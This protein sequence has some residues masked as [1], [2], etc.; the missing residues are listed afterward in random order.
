MSGEDNLE[1]TRELL[2]S[3]LI[4]VLS[5]SAIYLAAITWSAPAVG[6]G[7]E[8]TILGR[9]AGIGSAIAPL[10]PSESKNEGYEE[11]YE[12]PFSAVLTL[13]EGRFAVLGH[14]EEMVR[15]FN[16]LRP[17]LS[18]AYASARAAGET[19]SE[20]VWLDVIK[21]GSVFDFRSDLP[22]EVI[23]RD[24]GAASD[25]LKGIFA[26]YIVLVPE[27]GLLVLFCREEGGRLMRFETDVLDIPFLDA[28][29]QFSPNGGSYAFEAGVD[30]ARLAFDEIVGLPLPE[31]TAWRAENV[32][33]KDDGA[34]A[35]RLLDAFGFNPAVVRKYTSGRGGEVYVS[36][37]GLLS[38]GEDG[39]I[40]FEPANDGL[41]VSDLVGGGQSGMYAAINAAR[42]L[43]QAC[44]LNDSARYYLR[45]A[46]DVEGTVTVIM[47]VEAGGLRLCEDG[48]YN[49]AVITVKG[50]YITAADM[51]LI[52][53]TADESE[54]YVLPEKQAAGIAPAAD[55]QM[56]LAYNGTENFY[57]LTRFFRYSEVG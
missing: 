52:S 55:S 26:R 41:R 45:Q 27:N 37:S 13:D 44:V 5:L 3:I 6:L 40:T 16:A 48:K 31:I 25:D 2:K 32:L 51:R 35:G 53:L 30:Y 29:G 21:R 8:S 39:R 57:R 49:Y 11:S 1:R 54:R 24:I 23:A 46:V 14:R 33:R 7:G 38:I 10:P 15:T 34:A 4:T 22:L 42:R 19:D 18:E 28:L 17:V 56:D 20:S 12:L 50:G 47:G 9:I 43:T 36:D